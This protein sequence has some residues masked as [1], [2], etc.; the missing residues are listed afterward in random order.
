VAALV[1]HEAL[2]VVAAAVLAAPL[3]DV[4]H[5]GS[6]YG[7]FVPLRGVARVYGRIETYMPGPFGNSGASFGHVGFVTPF[8]ILWHRRG[9]H[10][11]L[12]GLLWALLVL[13]AGERLLPQAAAWI[14]LCTFVG[15]LSHLALDGLNVAGEWL[16]WPVV[17]RE[18][19]L[20]WPSVRVGS[21][22]EGLVT[23]ALVAL[24]VVAARGWLPH[25]AA[26]RAPLG[27]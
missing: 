15:Y 23:L 13:L 12:A 14:A 9:M 5:P 16:L 11:V 7:R 1:P 21:L 2:P 6:S 26:L 19:R 8:G 3:P 4:D 10:S 25:L 17:R 22:G 27:P 24:V 20:A 18:V